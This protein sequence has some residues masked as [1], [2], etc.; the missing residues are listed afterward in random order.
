MA[1]VGRTGRLKHPKLARVLDVGEHERWPYAVYERG[2]FV[3]WGEKLTSKGLPGAELTQWSVQVLQ[4][5]AFAHEAGSAH[6]DLQPYSLLVDDAG[7][8]KLLGLEIV[9]AHS[10]AQSFIHS[11]RTPTAT[12]PRWTSAACSAWPPRSTCWPSA[13]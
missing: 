11:R 8:V 6:R 13:W 9:D 4:G 10:F 1:R 3:T 7:N 2:A 5:L 12:R